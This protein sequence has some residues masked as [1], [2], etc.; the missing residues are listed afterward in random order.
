MDMHDIAVQI[1]GQ[2]SRWKL[3]QGAI[4]AVAEDGTLSV[5]VAGSAVVLTGIK[6]FDSVSP[7]PGAAVWLATDG[8]DLFAIGTISPPA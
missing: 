5:T 4:T 3:R 8:R 7:A 6:A 2:Q 1:A